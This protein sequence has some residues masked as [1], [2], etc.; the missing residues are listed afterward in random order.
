MKRTKRRLTLEPLEDRTLLATCNVTRLGDF[1]AGGTIG[2]FSRG[3]LRFCINKTNAEPGQDT[4]NL[5][6]TG[7][8]NL[9]AALPDIS[10]DVIMLG[11]G[12][13]NLTVRRNTGG[14]YR[15]FTVAGGTVEIRDLTV[16]NGESNV[17]GGIYNQASLTLDGVV[18]SDNRSEVVGNPELPQGGGV[19]NAGSLTITNSTISNNVSTSGHDTYGGGI[20]NLGTLL[21]YNTT[22][23]NNRASSDGH[24]PEDGYGGGIFNA[25]SGVAVLN[26]T[27]VLDNEAD[28]RNAFGGGIHNLGSLSVH[29]SAIV[30]NSA[31]P[32]GA[33]TPTLAEGGGIYNEGTFNV[34]NS[35]LA[36][37]SA[38][39]CVYGH[40][41]A[42]G[43]G[44]GI[45]NKAGSGT[46]INSTIVD[47]WAA[48]SNADFF[49]DLTRAF[50]G[51]IAHRGGALTVL[52]TTIASNDA[53]GAS[54]NHIAAGGGIL[55]EA[56]LDMRNTIVAAN[57]S[58]SD[59]DISGT[60]ASSGYN[61]IEDSSGG[62]GYA[63]TDILDVDPMLGPLADNGGPTQTIALQPGSPA[64]DSGDNTDAPEFD[65]RGPGFPRIVNGAID[66]GSFEVQST[67][68]PKADLYLVLLLTADLND[69]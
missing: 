15:I 43:Y 5:N 29:E 8:I 53:F 32:K 55:I 25:G 4:I 20:H 31:M 66:I 51:G 65:Q 36:E 14:D 42:D 17:G 39:A 59:V 9:T 2:D 52:H 19:Y 47:N 10:D 34:A 58:D 23:S 56:T 49:N 7:T 11:P 38:F 40:S 35:T 28:G 46:I 26:S 13:G 67:G 62:S 61:L 24:G 6:V 45:V 64:I 12:A 44:G 3:D 37:N 18:I 63:T 68:V 41:T 50:G 27:K 60:L 22:I 69:D 48:A 16:S 1:G 30:N 21:L 57:F 33:S 54:P